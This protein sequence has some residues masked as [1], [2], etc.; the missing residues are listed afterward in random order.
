MLDPAGVC[1]GCREVEHRRA[2][3]V[4]GGQLARRGAL[5]RNRP[6]RAPDPTRRPTRPTRGAEQEI[7]IANRSGTSCRRRAHVR[8]GLTIEISYRPSAFEELAPPRSSRRSQGLAAGFIPRG[9]WSSG[10]TNSSGNLDRRPLRDSWFRPP[11]ASV[12]SA[13]A[14][15]AS[16]SA[17]AVQTSVRMGRLDPLKGVCRDPVRRR[18]SDDRDFLPPFSLRGAGSATIRLRRGLARRQRECVRDL[19]SA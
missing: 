11:H 13:A 12:D 8:F 7:S 2:R 10:M 5:P 1:G 16:P 14:R 4:R 18:W 6:P 15:P 19:A 17:R 3:I 9:C